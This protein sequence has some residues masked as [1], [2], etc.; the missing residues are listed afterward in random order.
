MSLLE[1]NADG[2]TSIGNDPATLLA[3]K[4]HAVLSPDPRWTEADSLL[5]GYLSS[6]ERIVDE[7][8]GSP[9]RSR[10]FT[11]SVEKMDRYRPNRQCWPF[12]QI[13]LPMRPVTGTPTIAWTAADGTTGTW[14]AGT[15]FTVYGASS[16]TPEIIFPY[17]FTLPCTVGV[18]YPFVVSFTAGGGIDVDIAKLLIFE[19]AAAYYRTPEMAGEKMSYVSKIFEANLS[20]LEAS[21]L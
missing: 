7:V 4:Y 8:T 14:T 17:N 10:S 12:W 20:S 5:S 18:P 1:R 9:Y 15:D 2:L 6:A 21:F 3:F 13:C 19:Y 11:Y 16:L